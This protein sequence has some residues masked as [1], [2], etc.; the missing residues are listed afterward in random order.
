MDQIYK[1][2]SQGCVFQECFLPM[3][4]LEVVDRSSWHLI[5]TASGVLRI[6]R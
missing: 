6:G 2:A 4:E 5:I 3:M 1:S